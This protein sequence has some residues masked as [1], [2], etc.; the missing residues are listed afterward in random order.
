[1]RNRG[2]L[3]VAVGLLLTL[4]TPTLANNPAFSEACNGCGAS[5]CEGKTFEFKI[6]CGTEGTSEVEICTRFST[7]PVFSCTPIAGGRDT[8]VCASSG[9]CKACV[10][11]KDPKTWSQVNASSAADFTVTWQNL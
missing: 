9:R 11:P 4:A 6:A 5:E 10:E 2:F 8:A 3:C 1:M 7:Q